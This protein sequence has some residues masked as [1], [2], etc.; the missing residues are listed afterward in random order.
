METVADS[1]MIRNRE[2]VDL[3]SD[4]SR[5]RNRAA[6]IQDPDFETYSRTMKLVIDIDQP[7]LI[8]QVLGV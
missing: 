1:R 4:F 5:L 6:H 8:F 3:L 2:F 7:G